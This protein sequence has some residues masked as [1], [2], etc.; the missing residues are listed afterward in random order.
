MDL[1]LVLMITSF[2]LGMVSTHAEL[3][4][5]EQPA[6]TDGKLSF[7]VLGDWGRRG[8]FNQSEVAHQMGRIGEKLDVDFVVSTG[9]NFYDDGLTGEQ[10][11]AFEESFTQIYTAKSLQKQWY[12]VLGNHDYRGNAE[13]Q[14]S[15]HLRKIDSRWLCLRSFIVN[16]ELAE[17][18]FV[19][20]TPFVKSYFTDAKG[21]TYDWRG[22]GNPRAYIANMIK[23][24]KVALRESSAKWKIVVGH[25]SIRSIGHHGDT[26]ELVSKLLPILKD[27]NV[28]FY[29]NGHD[30]CLEHI[31]DTESPLQFLTSGA[32]SKAWRGDIKE[33]KTEGVKFFYDGQGFMSV[34]LTRSAAEMAFYDVSGNVLHRWNSTK[35]L[36]SSI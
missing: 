23:D 30:H 32:G 1:C 35:L 8:D 9:D 17:I 11:K 7:L 31:S 3:Q 15:L 4:R 13:A 12:S 20:T 28:D 22:I 2:G 29:M 10:D 25:H 33:Q 14:L 16:A 6:K 24:L 18:F 26:K 5:F 21:H 27:N 19:D 34:Q 36:Y